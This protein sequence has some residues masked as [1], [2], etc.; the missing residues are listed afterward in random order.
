MEE[1]SKP[2]CQKFNR[3]QSNRVPEDCWISL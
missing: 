1:E 3:Y 2:Y